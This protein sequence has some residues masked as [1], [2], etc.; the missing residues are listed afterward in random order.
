MKRPLRP[1]D[2]L[3]LKVLSD[4]RLSPDGLHVAAVLKEALPSG[5]GYRQTLWIFPTDPEKKPFSIGEGTH[6]RWS[7]HGHLLAYR[8]PEKE[9]KLLPFEGE[10][11]GEASSLPGVPPGWGEIAFSP[12]GKRLA[13]VA[14]WDGYPSLPPHLFPGPREAYAS[15]ARVYTRAFIRED[16]QGWRGK[17]RWRLYL[18]DLEDP[19]QEARLLWPDLEDD[20]L[21]EPSFSPS[22]TFLAFTRRW[23]PTP[24]APSWGRSQVWGVDLQE[25]K[26]IPRPL[27]PPGLEAFS[28]FFSED[29]ACL[30]F[31]GRP[32]EEG[33]GAHHHLYALDRASGKVTDL[34][35]GFDRSLGTHV[36]SYERGDH[37]GPA[38][39]LGGGRLYFL[40]T[41]GGTQPLWVLSP[42]GSSPQ[43]LFPEEAVIPGFSLTPDGRWVAF[44]KETATSPGDLFVARLEEEGGEVRV[45]EVRQLTHL[46]EEFLRDKKVFSPRPLKAKGPLGW[47]VEGWVLED[48]D[49]PGPK[50][51]ILNIH[52]GPHGTWGYTF[53]MENQI[54]AGAGFRVVYGN[55]RGSQGYGQAFTQAVVGRWGEDDARDLVALVE[56]ALAL[57]GADRERVGVMGN[58]YGGYMTNWLMARYGQLFKAGVT[59]GTISNLVSFFGESD[60]G[61]VRPKGRE[62][63][64][65]WEDE[66]LFLRS[67]LR[68]V[69]GVQGPVLILHGEED[70]RCPLGQ[71]LEWYEALQVRG[72]EAALV[73]YP[74]ESHG[75]TRTGKPTH[76]VDRLQ[77]HLDWFARTLK[78]EETT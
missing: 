30:Y 15:T 8:G 77:R 61:F 12:D 26:A 66:S 63:E 59:Q 39:A 35:Q 24:E 76:R 47:E 49:L 14:P 50:P 32:V 65:P 38:A 29:E 74:G 70:F 41:H 45:G 37:P 31:I 25:E 4:V 27:T 19:G 36:R 10:R 67:P 7:P 72:V 3:H 18:L 42:D 60:Y 53:M 46:H 48:P 57:P 40:A 43:N 17:A 51:L 64:T 73:I 56:E 22:G 1:E 28:A 11:P 71:A 34:L 69:E 68:W 9:L 2:L 52:G 21:G 78:G 23:A 13:V 58:S 6:P 62:K 16:G 20:D 5:E 54:L 75:F 33:P 55:P 44:V